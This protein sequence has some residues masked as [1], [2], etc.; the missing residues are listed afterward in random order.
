[1]GKIIQFPGAEG[2]EQAVER[3]PEEMQ[4]M[5]TAHDALVN[6]THDATVST[7]SL[8]YGPQIMRQMDDGGAWDVEPLDGASEQEGPNLTLVQDIE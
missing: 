6:A 1:M 3:S 5:R 4:V 7:G 2:P 8:E